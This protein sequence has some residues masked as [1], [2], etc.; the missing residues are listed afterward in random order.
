MILEKLDK[1]TRLEQDLLDSEDIPYLLI[2]GARFDDI[3]AFIY[4]LNH[5]PEFSI[6]FMGTYFE[7]V[8]EGSPCL[9]RL[10]EENIMFLSWFFEEQDSCKKGLL[11]FSEYEREALAEHLKQF[12]EAEMPD[13]EV[14]FFRFYDPFVFH[15]LAPLHEKKNMSAILKPFR[16]IYWHYNDAYY[17]LREL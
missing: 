12:F 2:D 8:L 15:F 4:S 14:V 7:S 1:E 5:D 17:M 10:T 6:L 3:Y 13:G 9:I 16:K 11:L